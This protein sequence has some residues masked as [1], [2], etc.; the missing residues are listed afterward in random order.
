MVA[1]AVAVLQQDQVSFLELRGTGS[2]LPGE[3]M[4]GRE[5]GED[6]V[7]RHVGA[8]QA[9]HIEGQ[10]DQ[11]RIELA[12]LQ[13]GDQPLGQVLPKIEPQL[14]EASPEQGKG[15]GQE[16]GGD[17]GDDAQSEPAREGLTGAAGGLNQFI[18]LIED[19]PRLGQGRLAHI[20]QDQA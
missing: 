7:V 19:D 6:L 8:V 1:Q 14:W 9:G 5:G 18:R 10:G 3:G 20:R 17:G 11:G 4:V 12:G 13:G 2:V 15:R 16:K